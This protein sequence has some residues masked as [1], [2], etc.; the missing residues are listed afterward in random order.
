M[1]FRPG[2]RAVEVL[3]LEVVKRLAG[4][5]MAELYL[6]QIKNTTHFAVIKAVSREKLQQG[7]IL[8]RESAVLSRLRFAGVPEWYGY[9]EDEKKQYYVMAYYEGKTLEELCGKGTIYGGAC[10]KET[11]CGIAWQKDVLCRKEPVKAERMKDRSMAQ[12]KK[13]ALQLCEI[14]YYLHQK[15]IVH[16]DIKPSN[17]LLTGEGNVVLL[18]YGTAVDLRGERY[19]AAFLGTAGYAAPE[20]LLGKQTD[21]T[22]LADLYSL[23]VTL[24]CLP[25]DV[26]LEAQKA[27]SVALLPEVGVRDVTSPS[28]VGKGVSRDL[29]AQKKNRW[30]SVLNK[31]CALNPEKRYQSIA[32]VYNEIQGL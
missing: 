23:G 27:D 6:A 10:P 20:C 16:G 30:Q 4:G 18:D 12:K 15:G 1:I 28:V 31:C 8:Q 25:E 5:S 11:A 26:C 17:I 32:Q 7:K 2:D 21:V 24:R 13:L 22:C 9:A 19:E 14:L 29:E 3:P